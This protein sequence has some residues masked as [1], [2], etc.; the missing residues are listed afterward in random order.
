MRL[1]ASEM[2]HVFGTT[3]KEEDSEVSA[4]SSEISTTVTLTT[5]HFSMGHAKMSQLNS[6]DP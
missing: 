4:R 2:A 3:Y 6:C 1:C 5:L